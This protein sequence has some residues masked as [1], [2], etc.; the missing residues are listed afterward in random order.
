GENFKRELERK[1][2]ITFNNP[3]PRGKILDRDLKIIV[4]NIPKS[5]ITDMNSGASQKRDA[6]NCNK[7]GQ[8]N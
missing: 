5:A 8:I 4:D 1:E 7:I 3:V 2:N 6:G